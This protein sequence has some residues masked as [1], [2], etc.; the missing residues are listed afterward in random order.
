MVLL[1]PKKDETTVIGAL[2]LTRS[3]AHE[4]LKSFS[5]YWVCKWFCV[6]INPFYGNIEPRKDFKVDC[7]IVCID[8]NKW[9]LIL[10]S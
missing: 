1:C 8:T 9:W 5:F 6:K 10:G 4:C 7:Q 2:L 3:D